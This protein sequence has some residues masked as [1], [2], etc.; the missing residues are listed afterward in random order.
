MELGTV[1][2]QVE[3]MGLRISGLINQLQIASEEGYE[4]SEPMSIGGPTGNYRLRSPYNATNVQFKV[5]LA[6]AKDTSASTIVLSTD[7]QIYTPGFTS[8]DIP[9][10]ELTP[11]KGIVVLVTN[12]TT[13]PVNSSWYDVTDSNGIIYAAVTS[14]AAAYATVQFRH[15]R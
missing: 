11:L 8:S 15:K 1:K 4:Y 2:T 12:N 6:T 3:D 9:T 7:P 5:D 10:S 14:T 13:V